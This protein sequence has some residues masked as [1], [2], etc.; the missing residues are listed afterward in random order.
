[1]KKRLAT[2]NTELATRNS[3]NTSGKLNE[4]DREI[5]ALRAKVEVFEARAV[6]YTAE[7]L[8]LFKAAG[9]ELSASVT[10]PATSDSRK[11]ARALPPGAAALANEAQKFFATREF[12]KAEAKY[13][14]ILKQDEN[15]VYTLANL[16]A[17]QMEMSKFDA[18]EKNVKKAIA[19]SP[20]D[21]YT[22]SIL[23]YLKFRQ[24]KYDDALDALSRAVK[25][26]P[27]SAEVQNYLGVTLSHKGQ[28]GPAETALRKA[29]QI[30]PNYGKAHNNLAVIYVSQTP[31]LVQLARWHYQKALACGHERNPELEKMLDKPAPKTP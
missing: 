7:E 3:S 25:L 18:A 4:L 31:P 14:E 10:G 17:I 16:A 15:N 28:R 27:Q 23:G 30:D 29:I 5:T 1:L 13:L 19:G 11:P 12:D 8:A 22:L 20:D 21:A 26:N 24:E 2:A 9:T 6:P